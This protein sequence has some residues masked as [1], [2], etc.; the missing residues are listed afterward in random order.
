MVQNLVP[1]LVYGRRVYYHEVSVSFGNR[2]N[3]EKLKHESLCGHL[4][5]ATIS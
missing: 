2:D 4:C 5:R 1:N 3:Q